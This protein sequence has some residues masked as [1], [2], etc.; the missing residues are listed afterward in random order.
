MSVVVTG[1]YI[2][3]QP[4][5][6]CFRVASNFTNYLQ[7]GVKRVTEYYLEGRIDAGEFLINATLLDA[8]GRKA[9][10]VVNNFPS[11]SGC[12][13]QMTPNG[14]RILTASGE[15]LLG[16]ELNGHICSLKGSIYDGSGGIVA[17]D[18]GD[19]FLMFRGPAVLGKSNGSLGIVLR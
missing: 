9:C 19:D 15:L 14:Y 5:Q 2:F 17:K 3:V 6:K 18:Q 13:R 7:L 4:G 1:N 16:I 8:T 11:G 12:R 10:Q